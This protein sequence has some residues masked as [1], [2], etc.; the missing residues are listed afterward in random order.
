MKLVQITD[1]HVS[2]LGGSPST[3]ATRFVEFI[4]ALE[5]DVVVRT[6]DVTILDPDV[7]QDRV[8]AKEI[9]AGIT[10]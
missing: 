4:N 8:A 3:N 5:P 1:T 7:D 10:L 2:H 9:L 6:G